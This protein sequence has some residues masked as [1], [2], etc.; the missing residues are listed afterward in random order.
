MISCWSYVFLTSS[1]RMQKTSIK[2]YTKDF[3]KIF[4]KHQHFFFNKSRVYIYGV[5]PL[6][7]I[8]FILL[9]SFLLKSIIAFLFLFLNMSSNFVSTSLVSFLFFDFFS[10]F[11][12]IQEHLDLPYYDFLLSLFLQI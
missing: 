4:C 3:N 6:T 5:F 2:S 10:F 7:A 11:S 1:V 8:D 9:H 12:E